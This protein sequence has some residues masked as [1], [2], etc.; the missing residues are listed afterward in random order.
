MRY[1]KTE[2]SLIL[3]GMLLLTLATGAFN[4]SVAQTKPKPKPKPTVKYYSVPANSVLRVRL[5]DDLYSEKAHIGDRFSSTLVDP[6]Y[7][8]NGVMLAPQGSTVT[9]HVTNVQRAEKNGKPAVMDVVFNGV[10]L[11]NGYHR[12]INGSLTDLDSK[13]G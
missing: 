2:T 4:E 5:N 10:R 6:V 1:R 11:P 13:G 9:G 3:A 8:K 12:A 7:S